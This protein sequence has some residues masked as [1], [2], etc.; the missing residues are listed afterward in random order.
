MTTTFRK[1]PVEIQ[2]VQLSWQNWNAVC[3]F[4][5]DAIGPD[6][7]ART[8]SADEASDTCGESGPDYIAVDLTTTHGETA[9]FRHGDWII[10]DSKPGTFYPCKPDI[11]EATY[12]PVGELEAAPLRVVVDPERNTVTPWA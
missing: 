6:N 1:K 2:A 9:V 3:E 4:V 11:F 8:I 12:E 5:G 10:P 7:P